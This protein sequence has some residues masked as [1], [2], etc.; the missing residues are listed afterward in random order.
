MK[1]SRSTGNTFVIRCKGN[2]RE[3]SILMNDFHH[4]FQWRLLIYVI[5]FL[6]EKTG[7]LR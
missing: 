5:D 6:C 3:C 7:S 1:E 4:I 2:G